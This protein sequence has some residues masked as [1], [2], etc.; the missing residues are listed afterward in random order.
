M[1]L[2]VLNVYKRLFT[3]NCCWF[4]SFALRVGGIGFLQNQTIQSKQKPKKTLNNIYFGRTAGLSIASPRSR[5]QNA[6]AELRAFHCNPWRNSSTQRVF[7]ES[8]LPVYAM[9]Q[10]Y[11]L[12]SQSGKLVYGLSILTC[13]QK[14]VR[15]NCT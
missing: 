4:R 3:A 12:P 14:S 5:P 1:R 9:A 8:R 10:A 15:L 13:I 6:H 2:S 11:V 7:T